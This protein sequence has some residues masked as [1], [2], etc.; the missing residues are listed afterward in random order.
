LKTISDKK[1]GAIWWIA[2]LVIVAIIAFFI[3]KPKK[4]SEVTVEYQAK[5]GNIKVSV[6]TTGVIQPQNRIVISPQI[7]GRLESV[8]VVE[9]DYV[10]KGQILAYMSST[11]RAALLDAARSQ[12]EKNMQEW[13][14]TYKPIP[15]IAPINGQVIVQTI[16]PG[17][18][19]S[20]TDAVI[21]LSDRLIVQAQVDETDIG[22]LKLGQKAN[23]S[24]DAYPNTIIEGTVDHINYESLTVNNVTIY[25]V[26]IL[27]KKVPDF[28]R[29]GMSA[30]IDVVEQEK[31]NVVLLP[32]E[33]VKTIDGKT[34]V[35]VKT[36]DAKKPEKREIVTG[37][38]NDDDDTEEIV[39]GLNAGD[40]VVVKKK[41]YVA[42]TGAQTVNPF[43][44]SRAPHTPSGG[45]HS[46]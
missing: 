34:F 17:Q 7:P 16:R 13:E 45:G 42:S 10:K 44:P 3:F 40:I 15:L 8:S 38:I 5:L 29:S 14:D 19:I 35:F 33:A 25:E 11:D 22:K 37:L 43:M 32:E 18:S 39:S 23:I 36:A 2:A 46:H 27:P 20:I 28:F 21:V 12:G 4:S 41:T 24:L 1:S 30:N 31:D 26:D 9:G 6:S